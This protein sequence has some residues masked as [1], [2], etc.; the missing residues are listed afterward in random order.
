MDLEKGTETRQRRKN[1]RRLGTSAVY[2]VQMSGNPLVL[3]HLC[4]VSVPF[5]GPSQLEMNF[6]RKL[7]PNFIK[8]PG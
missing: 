5:S 1:E 2:F 8:R 3:F 6:Y 4:L 7:P